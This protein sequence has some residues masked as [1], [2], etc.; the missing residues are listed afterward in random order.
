MKQRHIKKKHKKDKVSRVNKMLEGAQDYHS[1]LFSRGQSK[2][3]RMAQ[4]H[5][6]TFSSTEE[7]SVE[8]KS[9]NSAKQ[10]RV[11]NDN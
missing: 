2:N 9:P 8:S 1:M 5:N 11:S 6:N 4:A 10:N 3:R 7:S